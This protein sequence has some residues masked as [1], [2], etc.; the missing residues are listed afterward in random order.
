MMGHS[1]RQLLDSYVYPVLAA[2][3]IPKLLLWLMDTY[4]IRNCFSC[5]TAAEGVCFRASATVH[6]PTGDASR[7]RLGRDTFVMGELILHDYG[8]RIEIG[9]YSWVGTN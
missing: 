1:K 7:I 9:E 3:Q 8:G 2:L 6:N 5:V 4:R